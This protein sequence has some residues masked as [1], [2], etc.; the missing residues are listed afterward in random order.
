MVRGRSLLCDQSAAGRADDARQAA[1]RHLLRYLLARLG[2]CCSMDRVV[3][4]H[5]R[6]CCGSPGPG[7]RPG[8]GRDLASTRRHSPCRSSERVR[9]R[10]FA[11][12]RLRLP[13]GL[14]DDIPFIVTAQRS[15]VAVLR[16]ALLSN[17]GYTNPMSSSPG[18]TALVE[19]TQDRGQP[20]LPVL[21]RAHKHRRRRDAQDGLASAT[22]SLIQASAFP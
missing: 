6:I 7:Q 19:W 21:P 15:A 22:E 11:K 13:G 2:Q 12:A 8:C 4:A 16:L 14:G 3:A 18:G 5:W 17:A 1:R 20:P 9:Y 10:G